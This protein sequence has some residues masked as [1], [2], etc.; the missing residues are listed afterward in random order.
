MYCKKFYYYYYY[1]WLL[2]RHHR[3]GLLV[4]HV[5]NC[6][7]YILA[8]QRRTQNWTEFSQTGHSHSKSSGVVT[9]HTHFKTNSPGR[10]AR[11]DDFGQRTNVGKCWRARLWNVMKG[12]SNFFVN[13]CRCVFMPE[14]PL[15]LVHPLPMRRNKEIPIQM[16]SRL[17]VIMEECERMGD[18]ISVSSDR[19]RCPFVSRVH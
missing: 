1:L 17:C 16:T 2:E 9:V 7:R 4:I 5:L 11:G 3:F 14:Q 12:I 13:W 10:D 15:K 19:P 18:S 8:R 6:I